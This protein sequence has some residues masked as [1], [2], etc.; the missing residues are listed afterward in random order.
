MPAASPAWIV[1]CARSRSSSAIAAGTRSGGKPSSGP[2]RS[3]PTTPGVAVAD[4]EAGDL[5]PAVGLPHRAEQ[6]ADG[7]RGPRGGGLGAAGG[8]AVEHRLDDR[9]DGQ[10]LR[11]R[12]APGR[13][14]PR[15]R[16]RRRRPGRARTRG[17]PG[18][19]RRGAAS[20]RRC[21]RTSPGSA[22]A[23]R[24][25]RP[26]RNQRPSALRVGRRQVAVAVLVGELEHRLR[27]QPAVQVV[28]QEDLGGAGEG[29]GVSG[30]G[31]AAL[32]HRGHG[33]HLT[34]H[35]SVRAAVLPAEGRDA[36][37]Q[38]RRRTRRRAPAR[39][40]QLPGAGGLLRGQRSRAG[41]PSA[42]PAPST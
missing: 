40:A 10:P 33:R 8:E 38:A 13:S 26:R 4:D 19:S 14:A 9:L 31:T 25:R 15:R 32:G 22:P 39:P 30:A 16:R 1:R 17:P 36:E 21:A 18:G 29:L 27:P 11:G 12:A 35:R 5:L 24:S 7:D 34:T 6:R 42:G 37:Q 28:V 3:K 2:A 23:S 20:R 41:T